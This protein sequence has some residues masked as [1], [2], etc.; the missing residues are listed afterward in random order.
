MTGVQTCALPIW[1]VVN[2]E[3]I[4]VKTTY[5]SKI[6]NLQTT[7]TEAIDS[8]G[9]PTNAI[10]MKHFEIAQTFISSLLIPLFDQLKSRIANLAN[11]IST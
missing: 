4:V 8:L 1:N 10:L 6:E 3:F 7:A 11:K 9:S 2:Q 5:N